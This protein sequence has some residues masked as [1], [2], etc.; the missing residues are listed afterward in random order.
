MFGRTAGTGT[1]V[2][3]PAVWAGSHLDTVPRGGKFDGALGV[4]AALEAVERAGR[5]TV[6]VFRDEERGCAGSRALVARGGPF[7]KAFLEVHIEQ[8]SRLADTGAPLGIVSGI[9][10]VSRGTLVVE[11]R[12]GHAGTTPMETRDDALV[13]AAELI[14]KIRETA[15]SIDGA[16]ATVGELTVEPGAVNVIPSRVTIS[17]D[18]RAPDRD[19][20]QR[21]IDALGFEPTYRTAPAEMD[22]DL[23]AAL[24]NEIE[25]R[26]LPVVELASGAGHDAGVLAAAGVPSAMLFVRSLNGGVSHS[27][28]ELSSEED[29]AVAIEVLAGVLERLG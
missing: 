10:G 11:G 6:A 29:V 1:T 5:G 24:R 9:V 15:E 8:G 12:A 13:R 16:V 27:P 23:R 25:A 19:R 14:L 17:V 21:L 26:G 7:P 3:V 20:C 22:P 4:V 28:D 18:A 2:P